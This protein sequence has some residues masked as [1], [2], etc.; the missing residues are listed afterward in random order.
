MGREA[1]GPNEVADTPGWR[2]SVSPIVGRNSRVSCSPDRTVVPCNT[3]RSLCGTA[4]VTMMSLPCGAASGAPVW[5]KAGLASRLAPASRKVRM[6]TPR[7]NRPGPGPC[8]SAR[9]LCDVIR[10]IKMKSV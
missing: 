5:A 9:R 7:K 4:A 3:S 1:L 6:N 8:A 2:A 10:Y